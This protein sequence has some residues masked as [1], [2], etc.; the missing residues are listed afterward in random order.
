MSSRDLDRIEKRARVASP[1]EGRTW[2][3]SPKA[4]NM[5]RPYVVVGRQEQVVAM[6]GFADDEANLPQTRADAEFFSGA[7]ADVLALVAE[8]RA[9]AG[10]SP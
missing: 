3:L 2:E 9:R 6:L 10:D 4:H 7:R 1:C 8:L 5:G